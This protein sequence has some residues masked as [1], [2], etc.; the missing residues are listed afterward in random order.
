MEAAVQVLGKPGRLVV[1]TKEKR[2]MRAILIDDY[3][4]LLA[5]LATLLRTY[6]GVEIVGRANTGS[7]GLKLASEQNPD[8]VLVDFSMPDMD[9]VAVTRRLKASPNPPKVVVMSFHAEPEY[10]DMAMHAGADAYLVKTDLYHELMPLLE[11]IAV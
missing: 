6:Q 8:L 3:P 10:R 9:G 5:A 2:P 7:D 11:R 4:P 1:V